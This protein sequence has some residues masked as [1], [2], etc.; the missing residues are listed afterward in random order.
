MINDER[1]Y[2][3]TQIALYEKQDGAADERIRSYYRTDYLSMQ[4]MVS[5]FCGSICFA[6]IFGVYAI[7]H[8]DELLLKVYGEDVVALITQIVLYY[9][10]FIV[11]F[12]LL[13]FIIYFFRYRSA[14]ANQRLLYKAYGKLMES[15]EAEEGQR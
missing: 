8:F 7:Y 6:L 13:T 14:L 2:Q 1:V 15:Y 10:I 12:L 5:F 4:M 3:M 11:A 9:L